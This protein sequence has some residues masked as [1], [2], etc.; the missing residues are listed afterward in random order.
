MSGIDPTES[1]GLFSRR[2]SKARP[3]R[4]RDEP[5]TGGEGRRK[6]DRA[7]AAGI[8]ALETLLCLSIFGPQPYAW[9]WVGSQVQHLLDSPTIGIATTMFGSL[10]TLLITVVLTKQLDDAWKLVRRAGGH[11]QD[12]GA[13]ER[14]FAVSVGIAMV[15]F[16]FWFL[17]IEG[18]APTV[19]PTT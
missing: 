4:Y 5:V 12:E 17:V 18:P 11:K 15:L 1:G 14:I 9:L 13:I 2:A 6:A 7:L 3:I 8:L 19:A 16:A 10:A